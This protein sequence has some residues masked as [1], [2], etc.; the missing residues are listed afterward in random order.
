MLYK[1]FCGDKYFAFVLLIYYML[2]LSV[3]LFIDLTNNFSY[4]HADVALGFRQ[5]KKG[6]RSAKEQ[7]STTVSVKRPFSRSLP[8]QRL[9]LLDRCECV[10]SSVRYEAQLT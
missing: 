10:R 4:A 6:L 2:R 5:K 7:K 1:S 8:N 3:W 9:V